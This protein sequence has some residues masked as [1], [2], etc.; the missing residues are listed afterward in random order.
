MKNVLGI[1]AVLIVLGVVA[2]Y[3]AYNSKH[4]AD[5]PALSSLVKAAPVVK[6]ICVTPIQNLSHKP[7]AMDGV[8]DE[9]VAQ[10]HKVG[11][12][13]RKISDGGAQCDA[14]TNAEVV[15]I[16]GRG[17]KTA[18]VDFRLTLT[19]EP[20]PR[21]SSSVEGKS[22]GGSLEKSVSEF[23]VNPDPKETA[24]AE[25]EAVVAALGKTAAQIDAAN[26]RGLP[27]WQAKEQ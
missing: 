23:T 13:S 22:G 24:G 18:R 12:E 27:G 21:L 17:R 10:L 8:D 4:P 2:Y 19:S 5:D 20:A 11:F 9:L 26:K 14:T 16:T 1:T 6:S 25:R 15:D 7:V 3:S